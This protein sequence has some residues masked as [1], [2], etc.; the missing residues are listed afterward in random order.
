MLGLSGLK[1]YRTRSSVRFIVNN[2]IGF[3]D[4]SAL[5]ALVAL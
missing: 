4:L 3:T 1:G 5:F 2:Q